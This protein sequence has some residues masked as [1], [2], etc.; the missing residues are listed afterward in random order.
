MPDE[1]FEQVNDY[2][3]RHGV[4]RS[5][6]FVIAFKDL[7]DK[8]EKASLTARI[9]EVLA[10]TGYPTEEDLADIAWVTE[11]SRGVLALYE[12]EEW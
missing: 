5:E 9:N 8:E 2:A 1:V 4:S 12:N 10:A 11:A 6:V 7:L 3:S